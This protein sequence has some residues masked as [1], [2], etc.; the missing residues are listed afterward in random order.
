M[1]DG[2]SFREVALH[3]DRNGG[4]TADFTIA[5]TLTTTVK[6]ED[7]AKSHVGGGY[8]YRESGLADAVT[9]NRFIFWRITDNVLHLVEQSLDYNLTGNSLKLQFAGGFL[10]PVVYI[11]ETRAHI[12]VLVATTSSVHRIVFSHPERLHRHGFALSSSSEG[13]Q[14][15]IF[16]DF[17]PRDLQEP[18]NTATFSHSCLTFSSWLCQDGN[19]LFALATGTGMILLIKLPPPGTDG[20]VEQFEL[21]QAGMI[22][23]LWSGLVPSSLRRDMLAADA[24]V[25]LVIHPFGKH[26]C[27]F[28]LCR[29][30]KLRIWS[31]QD[32][33][34]IHVK[35]LLEDI[36]DDVDVQS[37]PAQSHLL[38]KVVD[39]ATGRFYLGLFLSIADNSQF[40]VYEVI[41]AK[42]GIILSQI[43]FSYFK[44][45]N[46]VDFAVTPSHIWTVWRNTEGETMVYV[47]P[48]EG[49]GLQ[50][51]SWT[52]VFLEPT[53]HFD[54]ESATYKEH[55]EVYLE[56]IFY[57]GRFSNNT[58]LKAMQ[59]YRHLPVSNI[60]NE[61]DETVS[62]RDLKQA[63]IN[64]IDSEIQMSAPDYEM[65]HDQFNSLQLHCWSKFFSYVV[66]YHQVASKVL[67]IF[68]DNNTG[69]VSLVR[70]EM[71]SFLRPCDLFEEVHLSP[72]P[73]DVSLLSQEP[74]AAKALKTSFVDF[75]NLI[76]MVSQQLTL[77]QMLA[78]D[79]D[80]K[81]Q[82]NPAITA[83]HIATFLLTSVSD[84]SDGSD[85]EQ[86]QGVDGHALYEFQQELETSLHKVNHFFKC[87]DFLLQGL[88]IQGIVKDGTGDQD[89]G[90]SDASHLMACSHLF[91]SHLSLSLLSKSC[92]QLV[93]SR[94][95][96]CKHLLVLLSLVTKLGIHK[97]GLEVRTAGD[98]SSVYIPQTVFLLRSYFALHWIMEQ[99]VTST[100]SNA[101][102]SNLKQL[103][104]LEINDGKDSKA[105]FDDPSLS[106]GEL[107]LCGIGGTQLRRHL[108]H[109]LKEMQEQDPQL[110]WS[111]YFNQ[112]VYTLLDLLWPS[113]ESV[114]FPEFLLTSYQ[115]L[116]IQEYAHLICY[117]CDTCQSSW[118]FLLGQ[119]HLVLG[120]YH[121]A[122]GYFLKAARGIGSKDSLMSKVLQTD[123]TDI[124]TL[125]VLFYVKVMK[126]FEQFDAPDYVIQVAHIALDLAPPDDSNI[127]NLW[128][129]IFKHHLELGQSDLAYN[130]L[131][132]NPDP[133]RRRDCLH[134]F[135][136]VLCER[137]ETRRLIEYP[138]INLQDEFEDIVESH[139]RTVDITTHNYYDML[140]AF[141]VFRG[142]FRK[143]GS[144]MYE[145][146]MRL[147]QEVSGLDSL[148]KQ[149]KCYLAAMNALHLVDPKNAWIV[150]PLDRVEINKPVEPPN[151]SPKRKQG[152]EGDLPYP[153]HKGAPRRKVTVLE[154]RD[155]EGEYLLVLA[156]LQLIKID[157]DP[158][159]ATGPLL[160]PQESVAL[161]TQA[162]LFDNA[163]TVASHFNLPKETIFEGLA[164]RCVK[165]SHQGTALTRQAEQDAWD[166]ILSNDLG[167]AQ[168]SGYK[169]VADQ[170]WQLLK[171][172]L[173]RLG[174]RD[175]YVYYRCVATKLLSAGATLPTWLVNDYKRV[176]APELLRLYINYDLLIEAV[177]LAVEYIQAVLGNG[178]EYF[179]LKNALHATSPS[180]WLPYTAMDQLLVLLKDVQPDSELAK[181]RDEL[182]EQLDTFHD[183]VVTVSRD[184]TTAQWK[185]AQ[186]FHAAE[187]I[188]I[189]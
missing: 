141:H 99:I 58:I 68:V 96:V 127:P 59:I 42:E 24:V 172:Y 16:T 73:M 176:N 9:R 11:F 54:V 53:D 101:I 185:R 130:A 166:W 171:L 75:C 41:A 61:V 150:K 21:Q 60:V 63:V 1:A 158:T 2:R 107:F 15:S 136:V 65:L 152:E 27:V 125:L 159:H 165:L 43:S 82:L 140:Y 92:H 52:R 151:M 14:Q 112:A 144:A 143:A 106:V 168:V 170:A 180:V 51:T 88:D 104:A 91:S 98:V 55:R 119:S 4:K 76:K 163:F 123:A 44:K 47:K 69:L 86:Q 102:E 10:L 95:S 146:A 34:C 72:E 31:C 77:E 78:F 57:P 49:G 183:Q 147:G 162:G 118:Y 160:S 149:A 30:L 89:T 177:T 169:S 17:S 120:E 28:A 182:V 124:P 115:Y 40:C 19:C 157:A 113:K 105:V 122:L 100:P 94:L 48:S 133:V 20:Q 175:G 145:H 37:S 22:Q 66:Q 109:V 35:D 50:Q 173:D 33:T 18:C 121:K 181:A 13:S 142:N 161:L 178:K 23:R 79:N 111:T 64:L 137:G 186:R 116:H 131:I 36:S 29:D 129:N 187:A 70:K 81:Y 80:V 153:G 67:G 174:S 39:P 90:L 139:A 114:L 126:L 74:V 108:A 179:G 32:Q 62:R 156:R 46:L 93:T 25:S 5:T 85:L 135:M 188:P 148:Q 134:K 132:A 164:S 155:L 167:E 6:D 12:S 45:E 97:I 189:E 138:F 128:S 26:M 56:Q 83:D 103:A 117:W 3:S 71:L 84:D 8:A 184:M 110:L 38:R 87:L 154:M 7:Y